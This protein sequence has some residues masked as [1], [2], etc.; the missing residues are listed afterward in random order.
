MLAP[1]T[2][3]QRLPQTG[4]EQASLEFGIGTALIMSALGLSGIEK[5]RNK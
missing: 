2:E 1:I 5:N 4:D 3:K